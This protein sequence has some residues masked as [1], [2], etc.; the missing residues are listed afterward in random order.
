MSRPEPHFGTSAT[1]PPVVASI[2]LVVV[3]TGCNNSRY[4]VMY[5]ERLPGIERV[6]I[7]PA[8]IEVL[9]RHTGGVLEKRPDLEPDVQARA[10]AAVREVLGKRGVDVD[11]LPPPLGEGQADETV[12]GQLVLLNAVREAIITHHYEHGKNRLFEYPTGSAVTVLRA[13]EDAD[14]VLCIYL[15]GVVPTAGREFLRGTAIVIGVLTGIQRHVSTNEALLVLMLVDAKT[16]DVLWFNWHQATT[17][18]RGERRLRSFAKR[19]C[20]YL[21]KPRK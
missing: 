3:V 4:G 20:S 7:V 21:L 2:L 1:C 5:D 13:A 15:T 12:A 11:V 18:V 9:S 17:D 6:A 10:L 14:A 8:A 19:A 16:G